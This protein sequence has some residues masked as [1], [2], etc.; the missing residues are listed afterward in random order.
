V[1]FVPRELLLLGIPPDL[2]S[3]TIAFSV[4]NGTDAPVEL[5]PAWLGTRSLQQDW[6]TVGPGEYRHYQL[7]VYLQAYTG[8]PIR[9]PVFVQ[10]RGE[11]VGPMYVSI[12]P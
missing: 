11:S 7:I 3:V 2:K 6:Q 10:T 12:H 5:G 8:F 4:R 1:E 9:K